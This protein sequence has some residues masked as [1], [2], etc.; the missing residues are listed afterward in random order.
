ALLVADAGRIRQVLVNLVG[1]AV[2]YTRTG[3]V[4]LLV[5]VDGAGDRVPEGRVA[6][7]FDVRDTGPGLTAEQR[8]QAFDRFARFASGDA[9]TENGG[10]AVVL[11][12]ARGSGSGGSAERRRSGE[13]DRSG[14]RGQDRDRGGSGLGLAISRELVGALGGE[15]SVDS[16]LHAGSRFW[17][18]LWLPVAWTTVSARAEDIAAGAVL[19]ADDDEVSRLVARAGLEAAGFSVDVVGDGAQAVEAARRRRYDVV[20]LDVRMPVLD[21]PEAAR[22]IL[23]DGAPVPVVAVTGEPDPTVHARC[24]AAGMRAVVAK[25]VDW[26]ALGKVLRGC[27]VDVLG[28]AVGE[29]GDVEATRG[30][31]GVPEAIAD[32]WDLDVRSDLVDSGVLPEAAAAFAATAPALAHEI[33]AAAD[34]ADST[35]VAAAAHRLAGAAAVIGARAL[36]EACRRIERLARRGEVPGPQGAADLAT[37]TESAVRGAAQPGTSSF[38]SQD[39]S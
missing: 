1:N 28:A 37:V 33:A 12:E 16:T 29:G 7:R 19:V 6:V 25:P 24:L 9:D 14:E 23:A 26:L 11:G 30:T 13:R 36:A 8:T 27:R 35:A 15:I 2:A 10:E 22:A 38:H 20:L 5:V 21:G 4:D 3:G 31:D 18:T 34:R 17:F 32:D 39:S